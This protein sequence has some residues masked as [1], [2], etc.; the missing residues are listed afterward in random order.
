MSQNDKI[1]YFYGP[2]RNDYMESEGLKFGNPDETG[3]WKKIS[4]FITKK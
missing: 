1:D 3:K 2:Y 4:E